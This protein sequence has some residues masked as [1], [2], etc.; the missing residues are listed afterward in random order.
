MG[1]RE[2]SGTLSLGGE[3]REQGSFPLR[4]REESG[5]L[6]LEGEGRVRVIYL[7]WTMTVRRTPR[8]FWATRWTSAGVTFLT[9][10]A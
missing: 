3:G 9:S 4:D 10:A 2:E 6:F 7:G 1:E 5:T 8:Y